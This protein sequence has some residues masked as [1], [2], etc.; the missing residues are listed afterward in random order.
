MASPAVSADFSARSFERGE[1]DVSW[2][3]NGG[4]LGLWLFE[5]YAGWMRRGG[6][7]RGG[8]VGPACVWVRA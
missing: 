8:K 5:I 7:G 1:K 3:E 2:V 6:K 4:V